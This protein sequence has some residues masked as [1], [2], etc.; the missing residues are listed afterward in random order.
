[1]TIKKKVAILFGGKSAEHEVSIRSANAVCKNIDR[2]RF[3][4]ILIYIDRAGDWI[5]IDE[6]RI[7]NPESAPGERI[8]FLPWQATGSDSHG[9]IDIYFPVLHGPNGEDGRIQGL[10]EMAGVPFTGAGSLASALAMDK[11]VSK[12]LFRDAGLTT[13]KYRVFSDNNPSAIVEEIEDSI[14]YP[15]FVKPNALGSSV[16]INRSSGRE[17]LKKDI[18]EAFRYD[19]RII[20]EEEICGMEYEVSVMGN[21]K[22]RASKPGSLVPS[23]EFYDYKD[24]YILGK[25]EF[26]IP[27]LLPDKKMNEMKAAAIQAYR[28]L[29]LNGFSR[30]DFFIEEGTDRIVINEINTIP[31]FTEISM[32]PKLWEAE[33]LGFKDLL[34]EL[35]GYGFLHCDQLFSKEHTPG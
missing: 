7:G 31:G 2:D 8:R 16:G 23:R 29:Y 19:T 15:C 26:H 21:E 12:T 3:S 13:A 14:G 17:D 28:S 22:P 32:F 25:T 18:A 33:G 35:I 4:P 5:F 30:A 9:G 20:V 34:T 11:S 27:A 1:M 6:D 24:K 10:F